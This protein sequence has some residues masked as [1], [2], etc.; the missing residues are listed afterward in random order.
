M[1]NLVTLI[2]HADS[3]IKGENDTLFRLSYVV[4]QIEKKAATKLLRVTQP[5]VPWRTGHLEGSGRVER[6]GEWVQVKYS[7]FSPQ[8]YDYAY[9]Q[10]LMNFE[11]PIRGKPQYL[12]E[13]VAKGEGYY[14][15]IMATEVVKYIQ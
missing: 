8:G 12:S 7:S 5:H 3:F 1:G 2:V 11:H 9:I 13:E 14:R 6:I 10:D 4:P 15:S